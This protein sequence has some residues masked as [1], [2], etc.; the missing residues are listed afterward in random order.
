MRSRPRDGQVSKSGRTYQPIL[1]PTPLRS[2]W[3]MGLTVE[4][5]HF[6]KSLPIIW[7]R[8]VKDGK[9]CD[10]CN[11][12]NLEMQQAISKL[13]EALRPLGIAPTLET[14]RDRR[15]IIQGQALGV[16]PH[17][18]RGQ[19]HGGMARCGSRKQSLLFRLRRVGVSN[20]RGRRNHVRG[21]SRGTLSE[22]CFGRCRSS[23]W[24]SRGRAATLV[25]PLLPAMITLH[26]RDNLQ[27]PRT[28]LP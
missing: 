4:R 2:R 14:R 9:T 16:Q 18:D 6:M 24:T 28:C 22:S 19:T 7:Q 1:K 25:K 5:D 8:L 27:S 10:R 23:C 15:R 12:T 20:R 26:T 21:Y 13:R 11:A 3:C 17:L